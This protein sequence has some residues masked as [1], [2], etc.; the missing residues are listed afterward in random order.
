MKHNPGDG[1]Q[2]WFTRKAR[3]LHILKPVES[4]PR[5]VRLPLG[6]ALQDVAIYRAGF[7]QVFRHEA[8]IRIEHLSMP[9]PDLCSRRAFHF[10]TGDSGEVLAEI[11]NVD[12]IAR[13]RDR[14]RADLLDRTHRH[15]RKRL[16]NRR[17]LES[18][19]YFTTFDFRLFT[20]LF[21]VCIFVKRCFGASVFLRTN[22]RFPAAVVES[23]L[24]PP[25]HL[26]AGVVGLPHEE[27]A[28][29]NGPLSGNLP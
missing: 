18:E 9:Q 25:S 12:A 1:I 2:I 16:Q 19:V 10:Q 11:E 5:C 17:P 27:I 21:R 23:R 7:A 22:R 8:S 24:A 13:G 3:H 6:I 15:T 26:F 4:E 14:D 20:R 29:A 28:L